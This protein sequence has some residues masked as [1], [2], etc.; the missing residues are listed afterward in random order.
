MIM[1]NGSESRWT[2]YVGMTQTCLCRHT[3]E[4]LATA[5][6][7]HFSVAD[8][9]LRVLRA[10]TTYV[11]IYAVANFTIDSKRLMTMIFTCGGLILVRHVPFV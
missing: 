7:L 10:G 4:K 3:Y 6:T 11:C 1:H 9:D 2:L 8:H 5:P